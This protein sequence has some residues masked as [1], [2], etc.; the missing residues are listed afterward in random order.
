MAAWHDTQALI[1]QT[2]VGN[3]HHSVDQQLCRWQLLSLDRLSSIEL[4]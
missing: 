3:R 4:T 2:A 1:T